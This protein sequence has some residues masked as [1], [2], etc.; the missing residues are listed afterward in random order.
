MRLSINPTVSNG[1]EK[2]VL[3][4]TDILGRWPL[5]A[6]FIAAIIMAPLVVVLFTMFS[7]GDDVWGHLVETV[8]PELILNTLFPENSFQALRIHC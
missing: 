8:L 3:A 4:G 5:A 6:T 7:P 2:G 1:L